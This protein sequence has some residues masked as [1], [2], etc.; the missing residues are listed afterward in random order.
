MKSFGGK[1]KVGCCLLIS[2]SLVFQAG[3][4]GD[5]GFLGLQDYQRDL[6]VGGL[7]A[8]ALLNASDAGTEPAAGATGARGADGAD[9]AQGE[10]GAAG[11]DGAQGEP[12]AAGADGATGPQ[13]PAG[14]AGSDGRNGSSGTNGTDGTD[15]LNCWDLNGDGIRNCHSPACDG[16]ENAIGLG[17]PTEINEDTNGDGIVD[18]LDCQGADGANGADGPSFFDIFIDDFFAV[19]GNPYG[20]LQINVVP[21]SEPALGTEDFGGDGTVAYRVAIPERYTSGNDVTMRLFLNRPDAAE[22][23]CLVFTLDARRLR[24]GEVVADYGV[25]RW[26]RVEQ[27]LSSAGLVIDIP[28]NSAAGLI[29]PD[30]LDVADL[31][32][33]ELTTAATLDRLTTCHGDGAYHL[34]GVEFFEG[35]PGSSVTSGATILDSAPEECCNF[36]Q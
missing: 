26:V 15:G 10:P 36:P 16:G 19:E 14:A 27:G 34:L 23:D 5:V 8:A 21:I 4:F 35:A 2:G 28:I 25:R 7:A 13:G 3:C 12:G 31:L 17:T 32:A 29:D 11:A 30:A 24:D 20:Q 18:V 9:G 1:S 6:L 33:F 22:A